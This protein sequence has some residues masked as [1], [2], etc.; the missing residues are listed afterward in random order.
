MPD[1]N[2]VLVLKAKEGSFS[3]YYPFT[4]WKN[5]LDAP[6]VTGRKCC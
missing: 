5:I 2:C 4:R 3:M 6:N 1:L